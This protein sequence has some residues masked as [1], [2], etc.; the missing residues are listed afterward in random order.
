MQCRNTRAIDTCRIC[1]QK[2]ACRFAGSEKA[3][4]Q[5]CRSVQRHDECRVCGRQRECRFPGTSN[6]ICNACALRRES[7]SVCGKVRLLGRRGDGGEAICWGCIPRVVEA[8]SQ[9]GREQRVNGRVDGAPYCQACYRR[10]PASF[11]ICVRCGTHGRLYQWRFCDRCTAEDKVRVMIPNEL[12]R[13][14]PRI[15]ALRGSFLGSDPSR[16]LV[17]CC[18]KARLTMGAPRCSRPHARSPELREPC[19]PHPRAG[20]TVGGPLACR[21]SSGTVG[22]GAVGVR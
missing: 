17:Y 7:C 12:A 10:H 5:E 2:V 22:V 21:P 16:V 4:C 20:A 6:A 1:D 18:A 11:R 14:D 15:T 3:I 8:C 13:S 19:H 9:C